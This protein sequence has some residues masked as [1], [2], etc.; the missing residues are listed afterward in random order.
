M[1]RPR[2]KPAEADRKRLEERITG[3]AAGRGLARE[4]SLVLSSNILPSVGELHMLEE[5]FENGGDPRPALARLLFQT[6]NYE[7][8]AE[9]FG[10][11]AR[12]TNLAPLWNDHGVS[13]SRTGNLKKAVK[14]YKRA[15]AIDG[16]MP[17]VWFNLGKA[18]YRLGNIE[19]AITCFSTSVELYPGNK[20]AWNNLGI[21]YR[22]VGK[23]GKARECY[24]KA[25]NIDENYAWAWHN[26]GILAIEEGDK[27]TARE[28][29]SNAVEAKPDYEPSLKMLSDL[30]KQEAC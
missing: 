20:S 14:A 27:M 30:S 9:L 29:F 23:A 28:Y 7:T 19:E 22:I 1:E 2:K 15:L 4:T 10:V 26:S 13:L 5:A 11:L 18:F 21:S 8:S 6:E 16:G 3:L 25:L 17:N 12:E 24:R